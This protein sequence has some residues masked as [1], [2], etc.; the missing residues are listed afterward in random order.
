MPL[1]FLDKNGTLITSQ[2]VSPTIQCG[3]QLA[4]SPVTNGPYIFDVDFDNKRGSLVPEHHP[5]SQALLEQLTA[6]EEAESRY[7]A[8]QKMA[9]LRK[10][11]ESADAK[12]GYAESVDTESVVA[13]S[14][15][16]ESEDSSD[17]V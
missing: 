9:E 13:K 15:D 10:D 8:K 4:F 17:E 11:A 3:I 12:S 6:R 16:A 7:E 14:T 5:D 2:F 1:E